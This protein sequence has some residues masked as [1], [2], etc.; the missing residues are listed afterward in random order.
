MSGRLALAAA[1]FHLLRG[2]ADEDGEASR[3]ASAL[4]LFAALPLTLALVGLAEVPGAEWQTG[5]MAQNVLSRALSSPRALVVTFI[6]QLWYLGLSTFG[7]LFVGS[8]F[9]LLRK[10]TPRST[11]V[12]WPFW[13]VLYGSA[14]GV[15]AVSVL[16]MTWRPGALF[17]HWI[18]GRYNEGVLLPLLLVALLA[19]REAEHNPLARDLPAELRRRG[20]R[21]PGPYLPPKDRLEPADRTALQLQHQQR[22]DL[23]RDA[24]LGAGS[25][26]PGSRPGLRAD[27][28]SDRR[29]L[30]S[31][32]RHPDSLLCPLDRGQLPG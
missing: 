18:Y 32:N 17:T 20:G 27:R 15:F 31:G 23:P 2:S 10:R 11:A 7:M 21:A 12:P 26:F 24:Q 22:P 30:A 13:W 16:F 9:L 6:G 4:A 1:A 29:A 14:A 8:F 5:S 28:C 19:L 3:R 25:R